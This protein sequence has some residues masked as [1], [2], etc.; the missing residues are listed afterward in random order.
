MGNSDH[1]TSHMREGGDDR[2]LRPW[3][4]IYVYSI[5]SRLIRR[6]IYESKSGWIGS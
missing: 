5:E 4:Y 1:G 3:H 2:E 6:V